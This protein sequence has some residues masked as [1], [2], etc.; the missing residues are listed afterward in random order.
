MYA[1]RSASN[2][3]LQQIQSSAAPPDAISSSLLVSLGRGMTTCCSPYSSSSGKRIGH[4]ADEGLGD[5]GELLRDVAR[6]AIAAAR[7]DRRPEI[8]AQVDPAPGNA[9]LRVGASLERRKRNGLRRLARRPQ[10]R[11][12]V[13]VPEHRR[14]GAGLGPGRRGTVRRLW[15]RPGQSQ[16]VLEKPLGHVARRHVTQR[17]TDPQRQGN[18]SE[19]RRDHTLVEANDVVMPA[20]A[21]QTLVVPH[22]DRAFRR[23]VEPDAPAQ[24]EHRAAGARVVRGPG[25]RSRSRARGRGSRRAQE[26]QSRRREPRAAATAESGAARSSG[27]S[28]GSSSEPD[29]SP[30]SR[31]T[32]HARQASSP[33][34]R[35]NSRSSTW[36]ATALV[37]MISSNGIGDDAAGRDRVAEPAQLL[38][39]PLV[40]LAALPQ[41][42]AVARL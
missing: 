16:D 30:G 40:R 41:H 6:V 35:P 42:R 5:G 7:D 23:P 19:E 24:I 1:G 27:S 15:K 9:M 22:F 37:S 34:D 8:G 4:E 17:V 18:H 38:V 33:P 20:I 12:P 29:A 36:S 10:R 11:Q 2:C 28:R 25:I 3:G 21:G 39:V 26:R 32:R 13:R 14:H 31:R